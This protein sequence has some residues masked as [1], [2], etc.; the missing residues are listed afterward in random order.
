MSRFTDC[1][2]RAV[3]LTP[4]RPLTQATWKEV[5]VP[6]RQPMSEEERKKRNRAAVKRWREAHPEWFRAWK[7]QN[8]E[9]RREQSRNCYQ[10]NAEIFRAASARYRRENREKCAA[11][12][13]QW[14]MNN[15]ERRLLDAV[16]RR[17][18]ISGDAYI[19]LLL[20]QEG[21]CAICRKPEVLRDNRSGLVKNLSVDHDHAT[22]AIRGL[23]CTRCNSAIAYFQED[24]ASLRRAAD[25]L[26]SNTPATP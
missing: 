21:V 4:N 6:K 19:Q 5:A 24:A 23:L 1:T 8:R 13:K 11:Y 3:G 26:E 12:N 17:H 16:A 25:Y 20:L 10:R 9:K 22:G 15:R 14:H 18:G 2:M 7:E